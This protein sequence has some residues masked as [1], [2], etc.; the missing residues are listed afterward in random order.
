MRWPPQVGFLAKFFDVVR[1]L[2]G[3][4]ERCPHRPRR[5]SVHTN[6]LLRQVVRQRLGKC[7]DG[8][9]G[10]RVIQQLFA[11]AQSGDRAGV[12]DRIPAMKMGQGRLGHVEVP[13][14]VGAKGFVK[15]LF[16]Q[17]V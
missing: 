13:V 6:A 15:A 1:R 2:V 17:V 16:C 14:D 9:L 10:G 7:M 8:A 4:I 3:G 11:A 5:H 12:D